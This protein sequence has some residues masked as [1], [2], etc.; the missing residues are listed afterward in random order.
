MTD[1]PITALLPRSAGHQ[2][3]IYGDSCSGVPDA[4][5]ERTFAAVNAV[6]RRLCP[7]P[8]FILFPGDEIE[9]LTP[10]PA[11]L[12]P[13]WRYWLDVEMAWLDRW[14]TPMWHTT[15]NQ[16]AY[17]KMSKAI[18]R[19]AMR[20]GGILYRSRTEIAW[21]SFQA[22]MATGL[23]K[24]RWPMSWNVGYGQQGSADRP[25]KGHNLTMKVRTYFA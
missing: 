5:H 12:R 8:Q 21:T 16:T 23:E 22:V 24:I 13:Q 25:F 2:F 4:L 17:D 20:P 9:G 7:Q 14:K 19:P 18:F 10:D 15:G 11:I 6:V 3:V 1:D